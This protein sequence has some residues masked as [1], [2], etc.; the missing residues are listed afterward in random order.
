MC[1]E[2]LY[3]VKGSMNNDVD[4]LL[5]RTEIVQI[6]ETRSIYVIIEFAFKKVLSLL[7]CDVYVN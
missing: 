1:F 5:A 6:T 4:A 2:Q 7:F 3:E